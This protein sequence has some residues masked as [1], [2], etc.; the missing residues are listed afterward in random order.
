[1]VV[2]VYVWMHA[3]DNS[4]AGALSV[5]P[6]DRLLQRRV[7]ASRLRCF[8]GRLALLSVNCS[9]RWLPVNVI[10]LAVVVA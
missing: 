9:S 8:V 5:C 7:A 4:R 10:W 2:Y 6:P 1:V 3:G